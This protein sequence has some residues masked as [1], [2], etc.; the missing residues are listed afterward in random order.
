MKVYSKSIKG[1]LF[2][3]QSVSN[4]GVNPMAGCEDVKTAI[5]VKMFKEVQES[6]QIAGSII[7][8]TAEISQEAMQACKAEKS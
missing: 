5:A 1:L 7:Q 3:V 8:D 2:M 4:A 6:Q